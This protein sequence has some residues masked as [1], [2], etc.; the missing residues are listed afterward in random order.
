MSGDEDYLN[1]II[2]FLHSINSHIFVTKPVSS[3]LFD[4]YEEEI[5][6]NAQD[7]GLTVPYDRFGWFYPVSNSFSLYVYLR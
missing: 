5:L 4:G 2:G 6:S 1:L 7:M 3:L